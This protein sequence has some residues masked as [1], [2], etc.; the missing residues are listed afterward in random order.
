VESRLSP[1]AVSEA[2]DERFAYRRILLSPTFLGSL[3]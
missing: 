3:A 2:A 1:V